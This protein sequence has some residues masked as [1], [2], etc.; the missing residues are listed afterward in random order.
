MQIRT[1]G[2]AIVALSLSSI[3]FLFVKLFPIMLEIID[4]HGCMCVF[5]VGCIIGAI[6]ALFILE[7]TKGK[8]LDDVG[9]DD[10]NK[11]ARV[12]RINSL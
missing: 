5:G 8:S 6:F 4:L 2:V 7:E 1:A 11:M 3:T 9:L 10:K 12:A